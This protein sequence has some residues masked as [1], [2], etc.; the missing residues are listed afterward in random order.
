MSIINHNYNKKHGKT[1]LTL[2]EMH[3]FLIELT[4]YN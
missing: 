4:K 3:N 2:N 1:K